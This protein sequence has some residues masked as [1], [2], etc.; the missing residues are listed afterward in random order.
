MRKVLIA[1]LFLALTNVAMA[2]TEDEMTS[3]S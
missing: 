1:G 3:L 2:S